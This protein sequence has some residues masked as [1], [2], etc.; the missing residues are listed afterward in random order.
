MCTLCC[1][2]RGWLFIVHRNNRSCKKKKGEKYDSW[3]YLFSFCTRWA[4]YL[5]RICNKTWEKKV[6]FWQNMNIDWNLCLD[7]ALMSRSV[8]QKVSF[9]ASFVLVS[10]RLWDNYVK[11]ITAPDGI[12]FCFASWCWWC[13]VELCLITESVWRTLTWR[14]RRMLAALWGNWLNIQGRNYSLIVER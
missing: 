2:L 3:T 10:S 13:T 4:K 5:T 7:N 8:V 14:K 12:V 1:W 11:V 9:V 6:W